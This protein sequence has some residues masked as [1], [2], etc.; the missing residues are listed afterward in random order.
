MA[1]GVTAPVVPAQAGSP[2]PQP[3]GTVSGIR[4]VVVVWMENKEAST[5]TAGSMPYL[6]G[7]SRTYGR[8]DQYFAVAHTSQPNY[9]ALWSGSTHGITNDGTYDLA[10][11]S[12]SGQ[13]AAAGR[14]WRIYAQD[15]PSAAG[16]HTASS[17]DGGTDGPGEPGTYVRKHVPAMSFSSVS[18]GDQCSN[19]QPLASFD[20]AV[21]LSFVVPNLCN[22]SHDCSLATGDAF[23]RAFLPAVF[24]APTW[25]HTLLVVSFDEGT[26]DTRGGG[27]V[28]TMV[29]RQGLSGFTSSTVHDHY[30]LLRTIEDIFGLPCLAMSCSAQPL[31]EFLP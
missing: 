20:P 26:S 13:M 8:A 25:D 17:Y 1:T 21:D 31:A 15:Y 24:A 23:L 9:L 22:D 10:G 19:I 5:V 4:H 2:G 6:Y 30:S 7:L 14:S 3:T 11:P 27:Q 18:G 28:F 16:C 12:L 29:A